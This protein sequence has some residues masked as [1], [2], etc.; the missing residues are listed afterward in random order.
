MFYRA[1]A[2]FI[3]QQVHNLTEKVVYKYFKKNLIYVCLYGD[4]PIKLQVRA[5]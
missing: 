3:K 2:N 1:F 4:S 5:V